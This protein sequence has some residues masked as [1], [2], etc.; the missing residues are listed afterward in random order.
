[1]SEKIKRTSNSKIPLKRMIKDLK[2]GN[3]NRFD[4]EEES[5]SDDFEEE[6]ENN[7]GDL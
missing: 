1:M 2:I 4:N 6:N 5:S 7:G 3:G